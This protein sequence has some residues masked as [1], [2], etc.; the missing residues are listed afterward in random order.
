MT[1][2]QLKFYFLSFDFEV[3]MEWY[4]NNIVDP[5]GDYKEQ[6][7]QYNREDA[8]KAIKNL[9]DL[10]TLWHIMGDDRTMIREDD[11]YIMVT[12]GDDP[13]IVTFSTMEDFFKYNDFEG[14]ASYLDTYPETLQELKHNFE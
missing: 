1:H 11:K 6:T 4:N 5:F 14:L 7:I 12:N 8:Q 9:Y 13:Y 2:E 3:F 10:E